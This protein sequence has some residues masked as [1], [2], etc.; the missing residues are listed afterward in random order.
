MYK[1]PK[2]DPE[3][4]LCSQEIFEYIPVYFDGAKQ[5]QIVI[6]LDEKEL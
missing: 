1:H 3:R 5:G 4:S 2:N 6:S